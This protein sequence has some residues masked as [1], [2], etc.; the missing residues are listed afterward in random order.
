MLKMLLISNSYSYNKGYLDHCLSD[1]KLFSENTKEITFVPYALN[2]KEE[3]FQLVKNRLAEIDLTVVSIHR[4]KNKKDVILNSKAIFVGGGNTF[5]LLKT[6]YD[7]GLLGSIREAV[8]E[9]TVYIGTSAGIVIAGPSIKTTNDM[10]IVFPPTFDA[11]HL[12]NF[13]INAHYVD[14]HPGDKM[15]IETRDRRIKEFQEQNKSIVL[16]LREDT[17]LHINNNSMIVKGKSGCKIFPVNG[18]PYD[19]IRDSDLSFLL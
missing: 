9:N 17:L 14:A 13:H 2:N 11:L 8:N 10:P 1:I 3:Y 7:E 4:Q 6:L 19:V 16:G 5:L 18:K 12:V 15:M